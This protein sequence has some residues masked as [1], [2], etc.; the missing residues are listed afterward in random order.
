M[1]LKTLDDILAGE[2]ITPAEK[3][4]LPKTENVGFTHLPVIILLDTSG[5]MSNGDA[6][7]RVS[8]AINDF[9]DSVTDPSAD[10][11]HRK[12]RR[13]ADICILRYGATVE[14]ITPS[15][16]GSFGATKTDWVA[17]GKLP[18]PANLRINAAGSTPMGQAIV[19][20]ADLLLNRY[21]GYK[22][23]GTKAFC[24]L[25]FNLTD[26]EPTDMDPEGTSAQR[27]LWQK[28]QSRVSLFEAMG[29]KK[30]PY[31]QYI[32]FGTNAD[33]CAKLRQFAGDKPLYMPTNNEEDIA[34][35]VNLLEGSDSF[36]KFVRFIEMSLNSIMAAEG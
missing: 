19:Q 10:E 17:G 8:S 5:S 23:S 2:T 30:N 24:G 15:T 11:F 36:D 26:G 35:R 3:D 14:P 31:A 4:L 29:S 27:E 18:R 16:D 7:G 12:L 25:V 21:R 6:I 28:A 20:S 9:L 22:V 1:A 32:H 34:Q 13:Q 33:S